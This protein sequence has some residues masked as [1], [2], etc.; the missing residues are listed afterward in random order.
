MPEA[1]KQGARQVNNAMIRRNT[2]NTS[3]DRYNLHCCPVPGSRGLSRRPQELVTNAYTGVSSCAPT[4]GPLAW[5]RQGRVTWA[6]NGHVPRY[7]FSETSRVDG[8][9][10]RLST[11][12]QNH[13]NSLTGVL[14]VLEG[15]DV[16]GQGRTATAVRYF[17]VEMIFTGAAGFL[18]SQLSER[19]LQEGYRLHALVRDSKKI[20]PLK[21]RVSKIVV[22]DIG[23]REVITELVTGCDVVIHTVSNFRTASGPPKSYWDVNVNGTQNVLEAAREAGVK[24]FIHCSTIGV[25]GHVKT[26]PATEESPYN[27][28]DLYQETKMHAELACRKAMEH[29]DMEIVIIRPCAMYGPGDTRMLKMFKMLAKRAFFLVGPCKENFHSVYIDDI[30][31]GFV[32]TIETPAIGGQ[33]FFIGDKEYVLLRHYFEIAAKALGMPP[34][35]IRFPYWSFYGAAVLCE[36]LCVPFGLEPPLH[37]RRVRFYRNNRAFSVD[38]ARRILQFEPKVPLEDGMRRT[39]AWYRQNGYLS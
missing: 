27:P 9:E 23:N 20:A 32:R 22:G 11:G 8:G 28:G 6:A 1:Y 4:P 10:A 18:G 25:H 29:G 21:G 33:I 37:R 36:T 39:V 19:L 24:R 14:V 38:K 5:V 7:L 34:P 30:V 16:S 26:T 35:F 31:E 13:L 17:L 3:R 12:M 15:A 2:R